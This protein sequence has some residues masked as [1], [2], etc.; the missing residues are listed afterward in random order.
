MALVGTLYNTC[1]HIKLTT[2]FCTCQRQTTQAFVTATFL[3]THCG[4]VL[5]L[6]RCIFGFTTVFVWAP[7]LH[8][9]PGCYD[10]CSA[11]SSSICLNLQ[12]T[13]AIEMKGVSV[14]MI[15]MLKNIP[16]RLR[17]H[18]SRLNRS[19]SNEDHTDTRNNTNTDAWNNTNTD[20]CR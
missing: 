20:M 17:T 16:Q 11:W 3:R 9:L 7:L 2:F 13:R 15:A 10:H 6:W 8:F 14:K 1:S 19:E 4:V 5:Q 12:R 18:R